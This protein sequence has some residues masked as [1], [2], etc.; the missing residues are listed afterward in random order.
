MGKFIV[1]VQD[2]D[3]GEVYRQFIEADDGTK[4]VV[5]AIQKVNSTVYDTPCED[6][7]DFLVVAVYP[8]FSDLTET[9]DEDVFDVMEVDDL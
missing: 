4:A 3:T 6:L 9:I 1:V 5:M 8:E 7:T 2:N